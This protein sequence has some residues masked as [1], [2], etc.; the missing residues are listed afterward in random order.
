M[1]QNTLSES[2][3]FSTLHAHTTFS[4]GKSTAEE[5]ILSAISKGAPEI[6]ISDHSYLRGEDWTITPAVYG[7]YYSTLLGLRDKYKDK[8]KV[9]IGVEQ[10]YL[11]EKFPY[12]LDYLI[13]SVHAFDIG[14]KYRSIDLSVDMTKEIIAEVFGGDPYLYAEAYYDSVSDVYN[15]THCDI[16]G[17]FDLVTKFIEVD[18][19]LDVTSPRYLKARDTALQKLID[20]PA[21][22]E[23]NTGAISRGYRTEPYPDLSVIKMLAEAGKP[24][25]LTSD[26]HS[27]ETVDFALAKT[28]EKLDML[29]IPYFTT[30]AEI[31]AY[32]EL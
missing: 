26:S 32:R 3:A 24:L 5:M 23:V 1:T 31:K 12:E 30:L 27:A 22:F 19:F 17:H 10:D 6:G 18:S 29:G 2:R 13:G 4:D 15:R 9:Y 14:G 28:A 16:I 7:E 25:I 11:S 21:V 20:A 8:I